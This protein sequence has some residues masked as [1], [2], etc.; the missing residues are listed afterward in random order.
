MKYITDENEYRAFLCA[1][2]IPLRATHSKGRFISA[3]FC[4]ESSP[5]PKVIVRD[6][7]ELK[8]SSHGL[9]GSL[10]IEVDEVIN[11]IQSITEKL[12]LKIFETL[13][14]FFGYQIVRFWNY[15][16]QVLSKIDASEVT[17][18]QLF[19]TGRY[20][21]YRAFYGDPFENIE[22]PAAS[23]VGTF[24]NIFKIEFLAIST[25]F[26]FIEN[27]EQI[28]AYFYSEKYGKIAPF[29]S[30]GVIFDNFNQHLL[31]SS[32]T[33]SIRGE[34]S[35]HERSLAGQLEKSIDN[36]RILGSEYNLRKHN[37]D[38]SFDL[39]DVYLFLAYYKNEEDRPFIEKFISK[40]FS[41]TCKIV[42]QHAEICREELLVEIEALFIKNRN[43]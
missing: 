13:N 27:K 39:K 4:D 40:Y 43:G 20:N 42:F 36:L 11:T 8:V 16:P 23:A 41:D 21:A 24:E 15:I 2:K 10:A 5:S 9:F 37:H 14:E 33:A 18:Y 3:W 29:F 26:K 19:N 6:S 1:N 25:P 12:Y 17:A 22:A 32:G 35:L 28:P 34:T 38:E 7:I 30:R 31:Y